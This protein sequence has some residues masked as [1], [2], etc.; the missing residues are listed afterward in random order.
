MQE[1]VKQI[2]PLIIF[3]WCCVVLACLPKN[4]TGMYVSILTDYFS[5]VQLIHV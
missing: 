4:L 2:F 5:V 1:R 3:D